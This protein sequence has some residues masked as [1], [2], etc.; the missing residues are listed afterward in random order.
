MTI[1]LIKKLKPKED[2]VM[3]WNTQAGKFTTNMKVK[4]Y[5]TLPEFRV[6]KIVAWNCHVDNSANIRYNI[7]IGRYI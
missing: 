2:T 7:I 6:T 1:R 3:Q 4:I 5:C